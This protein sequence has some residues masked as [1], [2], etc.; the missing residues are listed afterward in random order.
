ML[1]LFP[2]FDASPDNIINL[3]SPTPASFSISQPSPVIAM[4][5]NRG[6]QIAA[7]AWA[8]VVLSSIATILRIYCRGFVI[9]SFGLDDWLAVVAQVCVPLF[10][11]K[12]RLLIIQCLKILFLVFCSYE[13]TG[14]KYGTGHHFADIPTEDFSK[15]MQVSTDHYE[16]TN[17]TPPCIHGP[18]LL[19]WSSSC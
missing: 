15:A 11:T 6:P 1:L 13:I 7:N 8:F 10:F 14:V 9:K 16:I 2:P 4:S 5:N 18:P 12:V 19:T 3:E 17:N